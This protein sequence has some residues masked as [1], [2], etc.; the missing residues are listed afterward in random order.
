MNTL[1]NAHA[2]AHGHAAPSGAAAARAAGKGGAHA[3]A[4]GAGAEPGDAFADLM[5]SLAQQDVPD[6]GARQASTDEAEAPD[7]S[8]APASAASWPSRPWPRA[9]RSNA[10]AGRH[11]R[12]NATATNSPPAPS[13]SNP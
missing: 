3:P 4:Q 7:G 12:P 6:D 13:V 2:P 1:S 11:A 5:Q 9:R 8:T 10:I